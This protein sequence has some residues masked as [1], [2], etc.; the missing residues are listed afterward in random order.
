LGVGREERL[1]SQVLQRNVLRCPQPHN[2]RAEDAKLDVISS[3]VNR[4]QQVTTADAC[5]RALVFPAN[6]YA[7][8]TGVTIGGAA[9]TPLWFRTP[10][11]VFWIGLLWRTTLSARSRE[12]VAG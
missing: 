2:N 1:D 7:A 10:L 3:D 12:G 6:V 11:Q 8:A 9:A 4:K 5:G